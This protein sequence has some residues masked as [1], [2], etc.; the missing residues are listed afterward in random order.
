M[1]SRARIQVTNNTAGLAGALHEEAK[2]KALQVGHIIRNRV[3]LGMA[4][5]KTGR[6]YR[7]PGTK[8]LYRASAPG[9]YPA[10]RT[11]ALRSSI[12]VALRG[13]GGNVTHVEVGTSVPYGAHLEK[14]LRPFLSKAALEE[15]ARILQILGTG[16]TIET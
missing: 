15:Q 16:W 3:L 12:K 14:G 10:V 7:V 11:D 1:S 13:S 2:R 6:W 4:G 5:P 8:K 9:E